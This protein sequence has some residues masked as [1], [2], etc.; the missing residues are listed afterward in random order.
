[1][2]KIFDANLKKDR[3]ILGAYLI[4]VFAHLMLYITMGS[5]YGNFKYCGGVTIDAKNKFYP[6]SELATYRCVTGDFNYKAMVK[7]PGNPP[8]SFRLGLR[9]YDYTEL[10]FYL[11]SPAV[12]FVCLRLFFYGGND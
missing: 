5:T 9:A 3:I 7:A 2:R 1:M 10:V 6:I 11:L 12:V 4:W 8:F